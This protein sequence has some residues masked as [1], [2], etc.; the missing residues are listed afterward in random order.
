M[1]N[2]ASVKRTRVDC[3]AMTVSSKEFRKGGM[4]VVRNKRGNDILFTIGDNEE[5]MGP[6]SVEVIF[7]PGAREN[8]RLG[9]VGARSASFCI[10]VHGFGF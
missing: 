4:E 2:W 6:N 10:S 7:P 8:A 3:A 9:T 5:M 1:P